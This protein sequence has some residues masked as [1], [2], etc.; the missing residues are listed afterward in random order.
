MKKLLIFDLDGTLIDTLIDL[1]NAVNHALKIKNF[2]QKDLEHVR[3][4]IGNGVAK[5]VARCIPDNEANSEYKSTLEEFR[6]YYSKHSLDFTIPY[7]GNL[8]ALINLKQEGYILT[9]ATNKLTDIARPL[10]EKFF[11]GLFNYVQGDEPGMDRKP[12]PMMIESICQKMGVE[13]ADAF[14]IGDTNVDMETAVNS[15]VDYV[16]V[17]YGYRTKDELKE[18]C[19]GKPTI[20][21]LSELSEY[22]KSSNL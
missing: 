8:E 10:I 19:P 18:Q 11:P 12:A 13:K 14:Y 6:K 20:D 7:D 22:L 9:V 1:K 15:K 3:K 5:L 21:S 16:L 4:S 2:P 17:T